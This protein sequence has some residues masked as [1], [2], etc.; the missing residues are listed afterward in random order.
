VTKVV[1]T[2][3]E[4]SVMEQAGDSRKN[5]KWPQ[6]EDKNRYSLEDVVCRIKPP[7]VKGHRGQFIFNDLP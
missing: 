7:E 5:W 6:R 2:E 1:G 3:I 4:V